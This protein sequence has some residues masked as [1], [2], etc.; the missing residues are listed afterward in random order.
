MLP[1]KKRTAFALVELLV[2]MHTVVVLPAVVLPAVVVGPSR[3]SLQRQK[4]ARS[5]EILRKVHLTLTFDANEHDGAFPAAERVV[6]SDA[7][8]AALAP[9]YSSERSIFA[10][11]AAG[12]TGRQFDFAQSP[13]CTRENLQGQP[14]H[15]PDLLLR[16]Q[17]ARHR[18]RAQ[19]LE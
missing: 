7:A 2:A 4:L 16:R 10:C 11:P 5:A 12:H 1:S 6:N 19:I 8:L 13:R 14:R 17:L 18:V 9:R 3:E 15:S